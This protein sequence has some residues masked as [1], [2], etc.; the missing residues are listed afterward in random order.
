[1]AC[2]ERGRAG[3][4][5]P[6]NR[7][8]RLVSL[9]REDVSCLAFWSR[10][11]R[12]LLPSLERL[13]RLGYPMIFNLT[14]T[15]LPRAFEPRAPSA[16]EAVDAARRLASAFSPEQVLW[17]YDP[18]LLSEATDAAWHLERFAGLARALEGATRSCT[19]SFLSFYAKVRRNLGGLERRGV[20]SPRE[21]AI[22]ERLALLEGLSAL[23]ASHGMRLQ[24][25]CG[26]ALVG[27]LVQ[28]AHCIDGALIE[29]LFGTPIPSAS[30]RPTR[31]ECGC[32]PSIDL[33]AYDTCPAGCLYCYANASP[34][35]AL[36]RAR[37]LA[38]SSPASAFLGLTPEESAAVLDGMGEIP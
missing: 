27:G 2:V 32:A 37:R 24:S 17:R 29:R 15:G 14:I 22:E 12:P 7:R 11:Y 36:K 10:D 8:P 21:P 33:G 9:A 3:V 31:P 26:D 23:A 30:G 25:C 20:P 4:L 5:H 34:E 16:G 38:P 18:I 19:F 13:R 28:K 1:M 35:A 6:F